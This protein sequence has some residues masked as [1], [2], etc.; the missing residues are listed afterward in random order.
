MIA[1]VASWDEERWETYKDA[2][3]QHQLGDRWEQFMKVVTSFMDD[4]GG[5]ENMLSFSG[6]LAP[7]LIWEWEKQ[8]QLPHNI[9]F[10]RLLAS[11][12]SQLSEV[13][14]TLQQY[15]RVK[16][17]VYCDSMV[18]S[19][20]STA[21]GVMHSTLKGKH[22]SAHIH[23]CCAVLCCTCAT[24]AFEQA[25]CVLMLSGAILKILQWPAMV[26]ILLVLIMMWSVCAF[27]CGTNCV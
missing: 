5:A 13:A 2:F 20:A 6:C 27:T 26:Q 3:K 15:P 10:V 24:A 12:L 23:M 7:G 14:H 16:F 17:V 8:Q 21:H 22:Q 9:R 19:N 1:L 4:T 11:D 18:A 25:F